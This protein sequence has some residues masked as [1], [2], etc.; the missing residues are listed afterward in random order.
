MRL[1]P[2]SDSETDFAVLP[3]ILHKKSADAKVGW[4]SDI[5]AVIMIFIYLMYNI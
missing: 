5:D 4:F 1:I 2:V 3:Q